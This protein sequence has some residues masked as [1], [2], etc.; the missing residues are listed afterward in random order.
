MSFIEEI[1]YPNLDRALALGELEPEDKGNYYT[2]TCPRCGKKEAYIYKT[3]VQIFCNRRDKCG[4]SQ[5][6]WDYIKERNGLSQRETLEELARLA[7][8]QLPDRFEGLKDETIKAD[9]WETAVDFFRAQ[10]RGEAGKEAREYL[11]TRGYSEQEAEAMGLGL[12]T[13]LSELKAYL[14]EHGH[15]SDAIEGVISSL[16]NISTDYK[17]VIPYH[18]PAGQI[19]G[20]IVRTISE[21]VKPK[22]LYNKG[23]NRETPFNL[24][25]ARG[26]S[27]LIIVEGFLDALAIRE[28][29]GLENVIAL[30]DSS[31][32][33]K[34]LDWCLKYGAKA[35]ILALDN[36]RAGADGAEKAIRLLLRNGLKAY[37]LRLPEGIKDPDELIR[38]RGPEAFKELYNNPDEI[39]R[40][41]AERILSRHDTKASKERDRAVEEAIA[42]MDEIHRPIERHDFEESVARGLGVTAELLESEFKGYK[43]RKTRETLKRD[44]R[45]SFEKGLRLIEAGDF[46]GFREHLKE[47]TQELQIETTTRMPELYTATLLEEDIRQARP[48][49]KTGYN[50]LD[51]LFLI[52][53]EAITIIGARPSHGK[54]TFLMN[55]AL[56]MAKAV[57]DRSFFFFSYE[58]SRRQIAVKFL[59]ILSGYT[60]EGGQNIKAL[61]DMLRGDGQDENSEARKSIERGKA[62][63]ENLTGSKR[64]WIIGEPYYVD[65]LTEVL[66]RLKNQCDIG[67]VFIDYIQ[68][69]KIAGRY[70]T[71]QMELQKVSEKILETAKK[72][73]IPIIL[74]AQLGRDP[75]HSDKVRLDNLREAGDI[76][77][78]ASLVLGLFNPA[79]EKA[80]EDIENNP[81]KEVDLRVT[82]LKNRNGPVNESRVLIFNRPLLTIKDKPAGWW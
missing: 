6:L 7:G 55:L 78:D 12:Y 65:E 44:Y 42:F 27:E 26:H 62:E 82:V 72:L 21:G 19:K 25:R 80:Q 16:K 22:Y 4:F 37:V 34:K 71:R 76:E 15:Q 1:I 79:M 77:Q 41:M 56:N 59:N 60:F 57:P 53:P 39:T 28:R 18:D 30:G 36:D 46:Q 48:G 69:I 31:F 38:K 33:Q 68:K 5:S 66:A 73:S 20:V 24:D 35:F 50:S 63:L 52:P 47:E 49:L 74:G 10:L 17:I 40:W 45:Q 81:G 58:E 8:V 32:S 23:L 51:D 11:K 9:T 13:S 54:T 43:E 3:G 70:A 14:L 29:A 2:L 64:L 61:E 67:A 75:Q